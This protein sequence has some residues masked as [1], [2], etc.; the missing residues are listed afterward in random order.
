MIGRRRTRR[1]GLHENGS[2]LGADE[3]SD[4]DSAATIISFSHL[5]FVQMYA[6][7]LYYGCT[8]NQNY[9]A[10]LDD[11]YSTNSHAQSKSQHFPLP[12]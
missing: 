3:A 8:R 10:K 6:L 2:R 4:S 5:L 1:M 7:L 9:N 11:S 12:V